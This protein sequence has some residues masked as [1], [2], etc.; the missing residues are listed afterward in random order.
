MTILRESITKEAR[1]PGMPQD[2]MRN[3]TKDKNRD[4]ASLV[5]KGS[6]RRV[7]MET[8]AKGGGEEK[9]GKICKQKLGR[10][11]W[12]DSKVLCSNSSDV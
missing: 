1:R 2:L 9:V 3:S 7:H 6:G 12:C 4:P 11:Y 5:K 10:G 8:K